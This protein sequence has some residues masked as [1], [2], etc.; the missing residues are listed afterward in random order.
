MIINM[1]FVDLRIKTFIFVAIMFLATAA[2]G[3]SAGYK[4]L[5][6]HGLFAGEAGAV[7][8]IASE[9]IPVTDLSQFPV[10]TSS[11]MEA[12]QFL[13]SFFIATG[14]MLF[15]LKIFKGKFFFEF[16]FGVAIW[17]GA[18]IIFGTMIK[19]A[20]VYLL[21]FTLIIFRYYVP[22]VFAQNIALII[23]IAGISASM[24]LTFSWENVA[25]ILSLLS[26]YDIIAV[27]K[28]QHMQKIFKGLAE[29][30]AILAMIAPPDISGFTTKLKDI[31]PLNDKFLYLGTGDVAL[32]IFFSV[33]VLPFGLM[34][35]IYVIA[36]ALI[37]LLAAHLFFVRQKERRPMPALPPIAAGAIIGFLISIIYISIL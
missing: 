27:Y 31:N 23:G 10:K 4:L 28:T 2:L 35:S 13:I 24:G 8:I 7:P 25:V 15:F 18:Q 32:P 22:R 12:Y 11:S 9:P 19:G 14:I 17:F 5:Y 1:E 6:G 20:P 33:S 37:G 26:V 16:F 21:A 3:I 36:G 29:K 34:N 30:G